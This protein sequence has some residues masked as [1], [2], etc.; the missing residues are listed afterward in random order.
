MK[1]VI[2]IVLIVGVVG[3]LGYYFFVNQSDARP[4]G[5]V[6]NIEAQEQKKEK[7]FITIINGTN[8]TL[9]CIEVTAGD[10]VDIGI[11]IDDPDEKS[12]SVEIEEAWEDYTDFTI[13]FTDVYD[14]HYIKTISDVP[15]S[16]KTDVKITQDDY[17][18]YDGDWFRRLEK[19]ANGD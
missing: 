3:A 12:Y 6:S 17:V 18:E 9:K 15:V 4:E 7:R 11:K 2:L 1:K 14:L 16:G 10:G 13:T 8:L 5:T 19:K